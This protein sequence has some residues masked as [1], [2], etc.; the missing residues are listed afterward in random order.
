MERSPDL[1]PSSAE[2]LLSGLAEDD[3]P[4]GFAPVAALLRAAAEPE[5]ACDAG[6]EA[7]TVAAM[8]AVL[9]PA[10]AP[11]RTLDHAT[12]RRPMFPTF[13]HTKLAAA[14]LAGGLALTGGAA[15]AATGALPDPVQDLVAD[16]AAKA[17]LDLPAGDKASER[18]E[19][20]AEKA[21]DRV[22][23]AAEKAADRVEKA[24]E[25]A[26]DR[27]EK[28]AGDGADDGGSPGRGPE[29]SN[30][31]RTTDATGADKGAQ[32]SAVASEGKSRSGRRGGGVD[33]SAASTS[34]TSTITPTTTVD[35]EP[36]EDVDH[37]GNS[38][39]GGRGRGR[40]GS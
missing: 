18:A 24:A 16:A 8:V 39:P 30:L 14:A 33:D 12:R 26:A 15:A 11:I 31:A 13:L 27:V 6:A 21:A 10:P 23:K 17:G 20:V 1:D 38:G 9:E 32:I 25:K 35:D 4:P 40:S 37:G 2:R 7:A 3:A 28:A 29:I 34:T 22:E 5:A 19:R 36:A